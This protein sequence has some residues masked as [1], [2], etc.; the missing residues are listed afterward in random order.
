MGRPIRKD[1]DYAY[2]FTNAQGCKDTVTLHLT[3]TGGVHTDTTATAC[4]SFT[5][6]RN[7][8]TYTKDGDYAYSFTN[9]QGCK[10]T[11]TLHLTIT[12]G[13][14]TDTT[15]TACSSFTWPR[16]G[17]TYTKDGDYAYSFTNAQG[18]KDAR[19][20]APDHHR[21]CPH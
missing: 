5:W 18:C 3:I 13:V 19:C 2:S 8:Q 12:G 17:Q 14:H 1:G 9:A 6:P 11:V 15:A 16:N 21:R 20:P 7:G 4:S 10:D